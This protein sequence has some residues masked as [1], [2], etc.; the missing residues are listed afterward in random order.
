MLGANSMQVNPY[1][2]EFSN[3]W[4]FKFGWWASIGFVV[5]YLATPTRELISA[6]FWNLDTF[7]QVMNFGKGV[8]EQRFGESENRRMFVFSSF[9][10][11]FSILEIFV[12]SVLNIFYG[13]PVSMGS[14]SA[15]YIRYFV[16]TSIFSSFSLVLIPAYACDYVIGACSMGYKPW[17]ALWGFSLLATMTIHS[18]PKIVGHYMNGLFSAD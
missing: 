13:N 4:L 8:Y 2:E 5:L 12:F 7:Y 14:R 1:T 6:L 16:C 17:V 11:N 18:V 10:L 15:K 9:F 3:G